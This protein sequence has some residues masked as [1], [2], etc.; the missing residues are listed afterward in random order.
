MAQ[1]RPSWRQTQTIAL[2]REIQ[3]TALRLFTERGYTE[4]TVAM[5]A[6]EV[7]VAQRTCFRHFPAKPDIVL[8]DAT[9][10]DLLTHFRARPVGEGVITAFREALRAGYATLSPEQ[11]VL[12]KHRTELIAAIPEVRAAHLDHLTSALH[13]FTAAVAERAGR[14]ADD[15]DVIAVSGAIIGIMMISQLDRPRPPASSAPS[16]PPAP[17]GDPVAA[18]DDALARLRRGF[19]AL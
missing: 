18:I 5:I 9:D 1:E 15:P 4:T 3:S 11:R 10:Y 7:G 8:W 19:G 14:E 13:E 16:A 6:E 2:K 17:R 12:D